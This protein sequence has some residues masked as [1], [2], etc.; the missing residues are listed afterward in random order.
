MRIEHIFLTLLALLLGFTLILTGGF[1]LL[2]QFDSTV[3]HFLTQIDLYSLGMGLLGFGVLWLA[4]FAWFSR[5][6]TIK[7]LMGG[8][9]MHEKIYKEV[10]LQTLRPLFPNDSIDCEVVICRKGKLE[11][12]AALPHFLEDEEK[13]Q[14]VESSLVSNLFKCGYDREFLLTLQYPA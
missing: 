13:A 14:E 3:K 1:L 12:F 6:R 11:I 2:A 4:L 8:C 5:R 7:I 9:Q 10:V